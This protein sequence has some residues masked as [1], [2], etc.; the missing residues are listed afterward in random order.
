MADA[1]DPGEGQ[2]DVEMKP[3]ENDGST[4]PNSSAS[5]E[6]PEAEVESDD[7]VVQECDIYLNRMYDPPDFVGDLYVLQYPLRPVYRPY[8]DQGEL[9]RVDL[10]EKSRRLRFVYK[11]N[12]NDNYEDDGAATG[13]KAQR[14]VL[15]SVVVSNPGCSYAV[16]VIHQGKMILTPI[17]AVNQL[18]PDFSH[19]DRAAA[20]VARGA[21]SS[22]A[23]TAKR[24]GDAGGGVDSSGSEAEETAL[25]NVDTNAGE[26][27]AVEVRYVG[28][29]TP[30]VQAPEPEEPWKRLDYY[31]KESPEARDIYSQHMVWPGVAAAEGENEGEEL[32]HPKLQDLQLD[33]DGETFLS[34]MC[35]SVKSHAERK[36]KAEAKGSDDGL[37]AFMLSRMPVEKQVEAI[38]RLYG[39]ASYTQHVRKR[40]PPSTI[41]MHGQDEALIKLLRRCAVIVAGNWIL[42]SEI[43][44][45]EGTEA[46]ARDML[47][48]L[49][50]KKGGSLNKG[51]Y[52]K[53]TG[54]FIKATQ[55]AA[56][57]EMTRQIA[58]PDG[59]GWKLKIPAD[60]EFMKRFPELINEFDQ[61]WEKKKAETI[62]KLGAYRAPGA[63]H[64]GSPANALASAAA[65][66]RVSMLVEARS[67]LSSGAMTVPE[68]RRLLQKNNRTTVIRE[69]EVQRALSESPGDVTQVRD[70]W[71]LASTGNEANDRFRTTL[72]KLFRQRDIVS[73][74]EILEEY[75]RLHGK[76]CNLTDFVIR[77]LLREISE[78]GEGETFVLK[79][80]TK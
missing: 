41:R 3:A 53:W 36:A 24:G 30:T 75:Q 25:A 22:T 51:D 11:L 45:F 78:R 1:S 58:V 71:M 52:E 54:I 46:C 8:S 27:V 33:G 43:A 67:A 40:L 14:H 47:M 16:G 4:L 79:G 15:N 13:A 50:T 74:S 39:V 55:P 59:T 5:K 70:Q 10:K 73:K 7:E 26:A 34:S 12:Q 77:Q 49:F 57:D 69:D 64:G 42:T 9:H 68:L 20:R 35:G 48:C 31:T 28:S 76:A 21:S 23:A 29:G 37:S 18:R 60:Q 19:V 65:R 61:W 6:N 72:M 66:Q 62:Q 80:L 17:R 44:N 2:A 56:R 38:V 32:T 63:V